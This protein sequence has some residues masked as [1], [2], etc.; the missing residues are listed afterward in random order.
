MDE[1]FGVLIP[2]RERPLRG[3]GVSTYPEIRGLVLEPPHFLLSLDAQ[4]NDC[5]PGCLP[6]F[7]PREDGRREA[8]QLATSPT[9]PRHGRGSDRGLVAVGGV[10]G[11]APGFSTCAS[12]SG[13]VCAASLK[14][15]RAAWE[16]CAATLP[17]DMERSRR[18]RST[19]FRSSAISA[20][21]VRAGRGRGVGSR[22]G[23]WMASSHIQGC[24]VLL[25][26]NQIEWT[27]GASTLSCEMC[28]GGH[29]PFTNTNES[30][31]GR[32][33]PEAPEGGASSSSS[34]W[35][36]IQPAAASSPADPVTCVS[37]FDQ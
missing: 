1:H 20:S 7:A 2:R 23:K 14:A 35:S 26:G 34:P 24:L 25:S 36:M 31:G 32:C 37:W 27:P 22:G 11:T 15:P 12:M 33:C 4:N 30:L 19:I 17:G 8:R 28:E 16:H 3:G 29:V 6:L 21:G 13:E 5:L 18:T 9:G 10:L